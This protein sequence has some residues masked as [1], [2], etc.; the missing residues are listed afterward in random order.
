MARTSQ[1][2]VVFFVYVIGSMLVQMFTVPQRFFFHFYV[3]AVLLTTCLVLSTWF[4][5]YK[6]MIPF[7]SESLQ[8]ATVPNHLIGGSHPFS[9]QKSTS[10]PVKHEF[11]YLGTH[12]FNWL[13][14]WL[15]FYTVAPLSLGSRCIPEVLDYVSSQIIEFSVRSHS[16]R[17]KVEFFW[18]EALKPLLNMG[19][20]QWFGA[21]LFLW[22]WM[23]QLQC[24]AILGS[25][26]KQRSADEYILPKGDWFEFVSCP[27]YLA[28]III[29]AGILLASGG[30][31]LTVWLLFFF[32]VSNLVFAAAETHRCFLLRAEL[33]QKSTAFLLDLCILHLSVTTS[34]SGLKLVTTE[35]NT[36][37]NDMMVLNCLLQI[38]SSISL[39]L[40]SHP[41]PLFSS[42]LVT[43]EPLVTGTLRH[44]CPAGNLPLLGSSFNNSHQSVYL[45]LGRPVATAAASSYFDY[46][47][48][49]SLFL[50]K[51][52]RSLLEY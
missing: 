9:I 36:L 21:V 11:E 44:R 13:L 19:W 48:S 52:V 45:Y 25:L 50:G 24:H 18:R 38:P 14:S 31:D 4:Y 23:H 29:Y 49:R 26:R 42:H 6:K 3:V 41:L 34:F 10:A 20:C 28:E 47:W 5:A 51:F 22:G 33:M 40:L 2:C 37:L 7:S 35:M 32:V 43:F 46:C 39:S 30:L 1:N 15:I 8:F 16:Q 17:P 27:H 12:A